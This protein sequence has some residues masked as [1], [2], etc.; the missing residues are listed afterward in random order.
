MH[1][2][3]AAYAPCASHRCGT[4][5]LPA[6]CARSLGVFL[7]LLSLCTTMAS[8]TIERPLDMIRL[9]LD[10]RVVVKLKGSRELRGKLFVR[11]V[12]VGFWE[13]LWP[14][15]AVLPP[16]GPTPYAPN[17]SRHPRHLT[18]T[19]H[20]ARLTQAFDEHVNMVLGDCE[21][22]HTTEELDAET[23]EIAIKRAVRSLGMLFVRGDTV[24]FI[25]PR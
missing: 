24:I 21:E 2:A 20:P 11:G 8:K 6:P 13:R 22:T 17:S 12:L 19:L 9:S 10:E 25:S 5:C 16:A 4:C 1:K 14:L 15:F 3:R 18:P 23:G 7:E